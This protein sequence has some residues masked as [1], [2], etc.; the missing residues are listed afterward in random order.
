MTVTVQPARYVTIA[1]AA[2]ITGYTEKAIERKI[3]R[4]DWA[5]GR[6]WKRAQDGRVLIDME[7]YSRWVENRQRAA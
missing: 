7:G 2:A 5:E 6:E 3:E 1:L 4:G